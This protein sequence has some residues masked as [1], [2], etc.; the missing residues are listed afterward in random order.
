MSATLPA[1]IGTVGGGVAI[2]H[3][4]LRA[5]DGDREQAVARLKA[6]YADG[7]LTDSELSWRSHAAYRAVGLGELQR[8]TADLPAPPRPRR[9]PPVLPL[10]VLAL[11]FAAWLVIVPPEVTLALVLIFSVLAVLAVFL[12]APV[13]I[14]LVL[15]FVAYRLIRARSAQSQRDHRSAVV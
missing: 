5:S 7:R 8:L 2:L 4:D 11:A 1:A 9:R 15:A 10:A 3:R 14:P 12:L 13:W 6:H